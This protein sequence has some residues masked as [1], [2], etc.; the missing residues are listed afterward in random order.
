MYG[1]KLPG[2][3]NL[4][5]VQY[6]DLLLWLAA[7]DDYI[8]LTQDVKIVNDKLKKTLLVTIG[9]LEFRK[10]VNTFILADENFETLIAAIKK[11]VRPLK[12]LVL[13]R[14]KFFKLEREPG[15]DLSSFVVRL[16]SCANF[17][18]FENKD[19]D[20]ITN[21]MI[22]DQFL[23]RLN[24]SKLTQNILCTWKY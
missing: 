5:S 14:Y 11:F 10:I 7:F 17:C 6:D 15:E 22:R 24:N 2:F 18:E 21:Q 12:K 20:S 13:E 23:R 8:T 9:G 1:I 16:R 4:N 19:I 3:L